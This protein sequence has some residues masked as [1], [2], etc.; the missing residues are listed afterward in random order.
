[1]VCLFL[2]V[3]FIAAISEKS[4]KDLF[5]SPK[6]FSYVDPVRARL[7]KTMIYLAHLNWEG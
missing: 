5:L 4:L 6:K 2:K 7:L 1:M 3:T